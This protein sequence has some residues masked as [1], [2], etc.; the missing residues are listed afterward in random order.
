MK[1]L[2]VEDERLA[3]QKLIRLLGE[4]DGSIQVV[5]ILKSVEE[6]VNWFL[7]NTA[8][9][10]IFMDIQLEDG[11]CFEIFENCLITI[12]CLLLVFSCFI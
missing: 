8:P 5:D 4:I 3:A 1:V 9:D 6:A 2:I 12:N 11:L 7:K 10:L